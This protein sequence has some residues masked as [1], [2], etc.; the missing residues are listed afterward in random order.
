MDAHHHS[1]GNISSKEELIAML[2]YMVNHNESHANEL[3]KINH[4]VNH[5]GNKNAFD[6]IEK[7]IAEYNN[8]NQHLANALKMIE[9]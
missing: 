9:E 6:E 1:H 8:G 4:T 5:L 2:K 7:A 3:E